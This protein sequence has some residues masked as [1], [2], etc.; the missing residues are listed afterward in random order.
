M[1]E[2]A[3]SLMV[4][5]AGASEASA[6]QTAEMRL[7]AQVAERCQ[8]HSM[9]ANAGALDVAT[10][11]NASQVS[12]VFD[13]NGARLRT[14]ASTQ[15]AVTFVGNQVLVRPYRPG[16]F[17]LRLRFDAHLDDVRTELRTY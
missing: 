13:A 12:F 2:L 16:R 7:R 3:F 4:L 5:A 9:R 6:A 1:G 11:C 8:I 14:A 10:N 17:T 15:A